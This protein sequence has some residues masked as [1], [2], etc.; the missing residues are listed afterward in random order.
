MTKPN[1]YD[2]RDMVRREAVIIAGGLKCAAY[3][4]CDPDT[5]QWSALQ[6]HVTY[7]NHV[8]AVLGEES[9]KLFAKFVEDCRAI[10]SN[11]T[12]EK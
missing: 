10:P 7:D 5:L 6:F 9:A 11:N 2:K 12:E 8:M 3:R 4:V 1:T